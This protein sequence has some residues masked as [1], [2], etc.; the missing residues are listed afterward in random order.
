MKKDLN[1]FKY[2]K[3]R[4][5]ITNFCLCLISLLGMIIIP[6]F[7]Y[8]ILSFVIKN[9]IVRNLIANISFILILY[10]MYYKDLNKEAKTFTKDVKS[11][12]NVAFKYYVL[13][14]MAMVFFNLI[15]TTL[16]HN[17][18]SNESQVRDMLYSTPIYTLF[19]IMILAPLQEEIIFRKSLQPLVKNKWIY[20][21]LCGLLF[22]SAHLLTNVLS[23][24]FV[25][26]DLIYIL[27]YGSLGFAFAL[28]DHETKTTFTSIAM[29]SLH[30]TVTGILLLISYF[31]GL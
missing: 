23:G 30:N 13:G 6:T 21:T 18:S 25:I 11:N 4:K 31:G 10:L 2:S 28:M 14:L 16:L 15:I 12:M 8:Y 24:I 7:I 5:F 17:I 26:S 3:D 1:L 27:P 9:D 29:H 19:N 22:G 20:A